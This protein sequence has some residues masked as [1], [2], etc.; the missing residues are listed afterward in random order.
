MEKKDEKRKKNLDWEVTRRMNKVI[1]EKGIV[2][3]AV[4][5]GSVQLSTLTRI[6][7][8]VEDF[9]K[10]SE[11]T[12]SGLYNF[13]GIFVLMCG[14]AAFQCAVIEWMMIWEASKKLN[15]QHPIKKRIADCDEV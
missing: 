8:V 15:S 12:S 9:G 5:V 2:R 1:S 11:T 13:H 14:I 6:F 7:R 10:C 4:F 3:M